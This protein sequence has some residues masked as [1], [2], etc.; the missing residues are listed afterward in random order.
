MSLEL[1]PG[2]EGAATVGW[3]L[4]GD[5]LGQVLDFTFMS[6]NFGHVIHQLQA[7]V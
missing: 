5:S 4:E 1:S 7:S 6:C 2:R 3:G